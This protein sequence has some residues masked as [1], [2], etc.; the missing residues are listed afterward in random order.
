MI[1]ELYILTK[2]IS[3]KP[4]QWR[5]TI[6]LL[7]FI[8]YLR[9]RHHIESFI[10]L[11]MIRLTVTEYLCH[12]WTPI[13]C[14]PDC[15]QERIQG[16]GTRTTPPPPKIWKNMIFFGVKSWF[17]T[18]NTPNII[19]SPSARRDFFKCPPL[20]WNPGSASDTP[21]STLT[22]RQRHNNQNEWDKKT[23]N[24]RQS[25]TQSTKDWATWTRYSKH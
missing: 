18:R 15:T 16:G 12:R 17:F 19:A 14:A 3:N 4:C 25:N 8:I 20:I 6:Y 24:G 5:S 23:C 1:Y 7:L 10:V 13:G 2:N 21:G 22:D 11:I 9:W